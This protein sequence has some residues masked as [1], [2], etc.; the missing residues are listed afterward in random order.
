MEAEQSQQQA[1]Q[2]QATLIGVAKHVLSE[3]LLLYLDRARALVAGDASLDS[4]SAP[5][6]AQCLVQTTGL[7]CW[8]CCVCV[9][10]QSHPDLREKCR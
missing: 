8:Q 7:Q 5:S 6:E 1:Q 4:A 9:R 10:A 3:E 2:Q